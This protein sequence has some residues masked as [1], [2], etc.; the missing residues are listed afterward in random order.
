MS[1]RLIVVLFAILCIECVT[2]QDLAPYPAAPANISSTASLVPKDEPGQRL[3]I[4]GTIFRADGKTPYPNM[5]LYFYQ[6]DDTGVYNRTD[7]SWQ[8]PRLHGW[9]KTTKDG[10]YT[11]NTIKPGSYPNG[12]NPAHIHVIVQLPGEQPKWIDDFLFAD[13]PYLSQEDIR[14]AHGKGAF[15]HIIQTVLNNNGVLEAERNII[16]K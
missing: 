3:V 10:R 1:K 9:L 5:V 8:R 11:I 6:T 13:D 2:A 14:N 4:R 15:S 16:L 7:N 12:R